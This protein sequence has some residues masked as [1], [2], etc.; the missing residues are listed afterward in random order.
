ML[1]TVTQSGYGRGRDPPEARHRRSPG[2]DPGALCSDRLLA[3][4]PEELQIAAANIDDPSALCCLVASTIRL[5]VEEKQRL[6]ELVDVEARLREVLLI[7]NR[8]QEVFEL[9]FVLVDSI[10]QVFDVAF[11][12]AGNVAA[13]PALVSES[14]AARP[15]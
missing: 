11:D 3:L 10:E 4:V 14:Q 2:R 5:K 9:D 6:L 13:R 12:G 15:R 8:E 7:L 1:F